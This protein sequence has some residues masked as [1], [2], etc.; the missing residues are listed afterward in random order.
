MNE[1]WQD[2]SVWKN[3]YAPVSGERHFTGI[4]VLKD[5]KYS[6]SPQLLSVLHQILS[7]V[8]KVKSISRKP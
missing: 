3:T 6:P 7:E 5:R 4:V 8:L 2:H 1:V